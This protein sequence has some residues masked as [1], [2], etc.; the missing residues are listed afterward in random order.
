M[1]QAH[2]DTD[3]RFCGA[4]TIVSH[5]DNVF[6]NKLLWSVEGDLDTHCNEG[7]LI[8][9]TAPKNVYIWGINVIVAVGDTAEPD[10]E[11]CI[12]PHPGPPTDPE[13]HSPDVYCYDRGGGGH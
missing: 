11:G 6:V 10:H 1:T 2:R 7:A 3:N 8:P 4:L 12:I 5:Q 13:G 9:I